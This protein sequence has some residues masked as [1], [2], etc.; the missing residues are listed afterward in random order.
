LPPVTTTMHGGKFDASVNYIATDINDT[1]LNLPP[2]T[3]TMHGGKFDAGV[4]YIATDIN[5]TGAKLATWYRWC[6]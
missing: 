1:A 2:V 3:T 4:K 5:D 6:P